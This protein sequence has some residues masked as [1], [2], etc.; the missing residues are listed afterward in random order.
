MALDFHIAKSENEASYKK[1][2]ASFDSQAH[3]LIF[4]RYGLPTGKFLLFKRMED[5]Y[6]DTKYAS[7]ELQALITEIKE[8]M[9][10]YSDNKQLKKQLNSIL[11]ICESAEKE[12]MNVW[13]YCD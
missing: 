12:N 1:S 4:Y 8:I 3:E 2:D 11:A 10:L 6:K 13:V 7:D 5:Y 9:V